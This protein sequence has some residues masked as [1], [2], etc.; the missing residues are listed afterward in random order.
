MHSAV[1]RKPSTLC[2]CRRRICVDLIITMLANLNSSISSYCAYASHIPRLICFATA[3]RIVYI[4]L[5]LVF[6]C[7]N[8]TLGFFVLQTVNVNSAS[9][10][11]M[12]KQAA[13][14]GEELTVKHM[15]IRN[16]EPSLLIRNTSLPPFPASAF[17]PSSISTPSHLKYA[18]TSLLNSTL[19]SPMPPENTMPSR[20][21][22]RTFECCEGVPRIL[23]RY[24]EI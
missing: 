23:T 8:S 24:E 19:F 16:L 21:G 1:A 9:H 3:S 5:V 18:I 6:F 7:H 11:G 12:T 17:F 10:L 14:R 4:A 15:N 2:T 20:D 13:S 22:A